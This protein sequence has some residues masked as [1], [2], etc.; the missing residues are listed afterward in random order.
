MEATTYYF[1]EFEPIYVSVNK[2]IDYNILYMS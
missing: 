1:N 2:V